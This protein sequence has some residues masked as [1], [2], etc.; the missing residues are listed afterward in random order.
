MFAEMFENLR[1]WSSKMG[2]RSLVMSKA[3]GLMGNLLSPPPATSPN[4][5]SVI[6]GGVSTTLE[7]AKDDPY[8]QAI[9]GQA[10]ALD[11]LAALIARQVPRNSTVIDVGAN[12]GLS[13]ILLARMTERVIAFEPSPP[14]VA[15]LRRNLERNGI[16][17][18]EVHAAAAS[19]EPGTLRFHVAQY[20][21]G[22]HV[23]AAGHVSGGTI[24]TVDVPAVTLDATILTPIAFIKIDAEGHEPDVLAGACRLLAR[25][26]PLIYTEVNIWCLSAF[27]G[28]SPGALVRRLW[29]AFE[30]G[31]AET[32]GQVSPLPDPYGFLHNMIVHAH[33]IADIVLRP[34]EG[35]SMPTLPELAWPEAALAALQAAQALAK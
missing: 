10:L 3:L 32:D 23:V 16:T 19:S 7:G 35:A 27:A 25:D 30:V 5:K 28:H 24:P 4:I 12:I 1:Y 31:K 26:R 6:L 8:F 15:F 11:G 29:E 17:N 20:G 18:V 22:S 34:R 14:N 33:G 13:T 9:E 2:R 21:A